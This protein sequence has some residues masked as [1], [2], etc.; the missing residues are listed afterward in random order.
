MRWNLS[1][2]YLKEL[3]KNGVPIVP[4]LWGD[5]VQA[6]DFAAWFQELA[7][8]ELVIKPV[9]GANGEFAY[10]VHADDHHVRLAEIAGA[11]RILA[12]G[13]ATGFD[14]RTLQVNSG[15]TRNAITSLVPG[16]L[17]DSVVTTRRSSGQSTRPVPD[18][19][20]SVTHCP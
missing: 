19:V 5:A 20:R 14:G 17:R 7:S 3:E 9:V 1:K 6:P 13:R 11:E 16:R 18:E 8:P 15:P 12:R 2:L 10:R 4:T